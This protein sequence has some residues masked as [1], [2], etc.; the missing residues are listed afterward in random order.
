[1]GTLQLP[2]NTQ[3]LGIGNMEPKWR[4]MN[5]IENGHIPAS[6][7][8]VSQRVCL[9]LG[10]FQECWV[11]L[12]WINCLFLYMYFYLFQ[13]MR[14][15]W[16][17]GMVNRSTHGWV[18]GLRPQNWKISWVIHELSGL[19][20]ALQDEALKK[21]LATLHLTLLK[22]PDVLGLERSQVC[23][24]DPLVTCHPLFHFHRFEVRSLEV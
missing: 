6:Y 22:S 16:A 23:T 13:H 11:E 9:F 19:S 17:C 14:V 7:V 20:P 10:G 3:L 1:M 15:D 18:H 12:W 2:P 24:N 4:C 8:I 21:R 5:P